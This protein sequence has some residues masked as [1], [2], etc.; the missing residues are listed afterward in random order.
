MLR[1]HLALYDTKRL[2]DD[3]WTSH[4]SE[5]MIH[6]RWA[7]DHDEDLKWIKN[8]LPELDSHIWIASSGTMS[9]TDQSKWIAISKKA[10][11]QNAQSVIDHLNIIPT[12][13]FYLTLPLAHVGGLGLWAR[14][15][16][17]NNSVFILNEHWNPESLKCEF[18]WI[19]LVPTQVF[20]IV[21]AQIPAP[22]NLKGAIVGGDHLKDSLL[23]N[24]QKL[25]WKIL[26]SYGM[27][28]VGSQIATEK[29]Q[30]SGLEILNHATLTTDSEDRLLIQSP[31]LFTGEAII[32]KQSIQWNKRSEEIWAA[33]DRAKIID[34]QIK[35]L[36]R[37]DSIVKIKGEKVDLFELENIVS[38]ELKID[39]IIKAQEH[40]RDG[41]QLCLYTEKE[42]DLNKVNANLLPHQRISS[43]IKIER[44]ER[45][46]LGKI[47]RS[48]YG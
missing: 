20:D 16:L 33:Q 42:L 18:E 38:S 21:E 7:K 47:K 44:F 30:G 24:I 19:S 41:I 17:Q 43:I 10:M 6:P 15:Y 48:I 8:N 28:E 29:S 9:S 23:N 4:S 40:A 39:L 25:G 3:F 31:C 32:K 2:P 13:R 26:R 37:I 35:V 1:V 46:P 22:K 11:L 34:N 36:G 27:S 5:L 12:D 45:T 14:A